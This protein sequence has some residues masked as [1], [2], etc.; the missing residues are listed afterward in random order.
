MLSKSLI[1]LT[2]S[3]LL[4][5]TA[6]ALARPVAPARFYQPAE[7]FAQPNHTKKTAI[8]AG[9]VNS[10]G[11]IVSGTGYSVSHDGA[12]EY[13]LDVPAGYFKECPA[14][15][16]LPAGL[17]GHLVIPDVYDYITCGNNGEVKM[18]I[19]LYERAGGALQDNAFHFAMI[20]T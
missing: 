1:A 17:N 20:D 3:V 11:S 9:I 7:T 4:G 10:N 6:I 13:T 18:Q 15:D 14:I 2:A 12:G 19:R 5:S 16:V 8:K